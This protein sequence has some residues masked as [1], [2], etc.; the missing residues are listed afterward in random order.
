M[1]GLDTERPEQ[2]K[3]KCDEERL[4][5]ESAVLVI[6]HRDMEN[7]KIWDMI[8][9]AHS[10]QRSAAEQEERILGTATIIGGCLEEKSPAPFPFSR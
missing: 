1:N 3:A 10:E 4:T 2:L 5:H 9:S 8:S 7:M 6:A